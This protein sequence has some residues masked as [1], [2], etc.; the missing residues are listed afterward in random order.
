MATS[1][2]AGT[3]PLKAGAKR[4]T[5][6]DLMAQQRL[7]GWLFMSPWIIGFLVFTATPIIFS[8]VMTFTNFNLA[9][10]DK[11]SWV[12]LRNWGRLFSDPDNL[13]AIRVT[14]TF[15]ALA[16]PVGVLQPVAM[17]SL[18]HSK[19]LKGRRIWTTLFYMPYIVPAVS[20]AFVWRA[21]LNGDSG[22]LNRMLRLVGV[23]NPPNYLQDPNWILPAFIMVGLWGVGNA[24][25]VTLASMQ[26]V[27]TELYEAAQV[28]GA[29]GWNQFL[30]ITLPM[31]SPVIFYNLVLGVIGLMQYFVVP[32]VLT[33]AG[34]GNPG[35]P[36][37]AALFMNLYFYKTAFTYLDMGYGATQAWLIF[38]IGLAATSLLFASARFW[39]YYSSG[40]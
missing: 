27:P 38:I 5:R 31:I 25:L 11:V 33:G 3:L 40:D 15:A 24:M 20:S 1:D 22:W 14:L 36:N 28:D 26:G 7:W 37:K 39:V 9:D 23:Q 19:W 29:G 6:G 12:G 16:L 17:A 35:D 8:L 13:Q 2:T 18:L 34:A 10:P 30:N 4:R 21:F 32:Y